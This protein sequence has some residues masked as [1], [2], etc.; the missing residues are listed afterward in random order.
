LTVISLLNSPLRRSP[1]AW[2]FGWFW[3]GTLG[4]FLLQRIGRGVQS[5][6]SGGR[7]TGSAIVPAERPRP[8]PAVASRSVAGGDALPT[9]VQRLE[10]R[11]AALE[12]WR[13]G[14]N[15]P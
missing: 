4:G 3:S 11:V 7:T 2:L 13:T 9:Q 14:S 12:Q 6:G 10:E 8:T 15:A 1:V 5:S